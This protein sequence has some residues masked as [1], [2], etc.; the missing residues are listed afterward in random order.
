M[1]G[2]CKPGM[3]KVL[4]GAVQVMLFWANFSPSDAKGMCCRTWTERSAGV[5]A[6]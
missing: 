4:L 1:F 5:A 6:A 2:I 3:L